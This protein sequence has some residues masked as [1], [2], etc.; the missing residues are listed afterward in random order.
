LFGNFSFRGTKSSPATAE[1]GLV[2]QSLAGGQPATNRRFTL[3]GSP[4][5]SPPDA[6]MPVLAIEKT[7]NFPNP[8]IIK[9]GKSF[10]DTVIETL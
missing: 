9:T 4:I 6:E 1:K 2:S 8:Q 10:V 7:G 3:P 5:I